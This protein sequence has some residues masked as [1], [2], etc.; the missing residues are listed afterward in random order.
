MIGATV[1]G[2]AIAVMALIMMASDESV[3]PIDTATTAA[4]NVVIVVVTGRR[5]K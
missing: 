2:S 3:I 1:I 4:T 5:Y